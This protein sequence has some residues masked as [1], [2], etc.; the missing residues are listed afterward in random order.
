MG[1]EARQQSASDYDTLSGGPAG[2]ERWP[3]TSFE[4]KPLKHHPVVAAVTS[5][6]LR[7]RNR[8]LEKLIFTAT[9]GRSGTLT[10]ARLFSAVPG[11]VAVHEG[12]PIMHGPVLRAASYGDRRLVDQ[13][14]RRVKSVNILR[15]AAGNRY[16][17]EANHLFIKTFIGNA[18]EDFG[19]RVAIIHLFRPAVEVAKSIYCLRDYPGTERGNY[20]WLDYRAPTNLIS[21]AHLLDA[22][23]E[24]SH[25]FYRA[26]WYW[27]EVEARIAAW[28]TRVPAINIA[29]FE[30]HWFNDA[31]RVFALLDT[32]GVEYDRPTI[33]A[34][35]GRRE[36]LKEHQKIDAA[37]HD[38]QA[39]R[40]AR[41]FAELVEDLARGPVPR[42]DERAATASAT[43]LE[44]RS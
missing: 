13:V 44:A 2:T 5:R 26:L 12:H 32:L 15:A 37:P 22:E 38:E 39:E 14:Y 6:V 35:V 23:G 16:Y 19:E 31:S 8:R 29:R 33:A 1:E 30:T 3:M 40:M 9:T 36:H 27:H 17:V 10:L 11:C 18:I 25:P 21:I 24:F 42:R 34:M 20:W 41:R 4:F 28:R 7:M 43:P